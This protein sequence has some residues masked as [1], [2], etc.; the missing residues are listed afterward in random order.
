MSYQ[1]LIDF[2]KRAPFPTLLKWH[3]ASRHVHMLEAINR[4]YGAREARVWLTGRVVLDEETEFRTAHFA[5]D[6]DTLI[7][8]D[9]D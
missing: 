3:R 4:T 7:P 1:A 9:T 6:P 2:C 5:P 8:Q